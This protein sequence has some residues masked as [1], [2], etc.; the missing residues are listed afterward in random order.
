MSKKFSNSKH[1]HGWTEEKVEKFVEDM[2][3]LI[4]YRYT[5]F[6]HKIAS[7]INLEMKKPAPTILD[8]GCGP[9]FLLFELRKLLPEIRLIGLDSSDLMLDAA[10]KKART[11]Q[12]KEIEFKKG[13][14]ENL[15]FT[16]NSIDYIVSQNS[17][18]DFKDVNE[19]LIQIYRVLVHGGMFLDKS[20][21]GGYP[22][23]KQKL[24]FIQIALRFGLR[25]AKMVFK[26]EEK[27]LNPTDNLRM[28]EKVGFEA[29]LLENG[30]EYMIR[31]RKR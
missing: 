2:E 25:E 17:L 22:K 28:M 5:P 21:N 4:E 1:H 16:D 7:F 10:K 14:A 13:F 29:N 31:G 19:S 24:K 26:G 3:D 18:H 20:R 15:P 27:W 23:W 9:G 8:V 12:D 6:A 30:F 11:K